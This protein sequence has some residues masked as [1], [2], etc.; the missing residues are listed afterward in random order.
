[1]YS[2]DGQKGR[3]EMAEFFSTRNRG[4]SVRGSEAIMKGI[5][6][7]GGL[8]VPDCFENIYGKCMKAKSYSDLCSTVLSSFFPE[9]D[10]SGDVESAYMKFSTNPPLCIKKAGDLH[11]M[12]L[13]HGPTCAFKDFALSVLPYLMRKS[14]EL[15]KD[16]LRTVI[17]TATSGDTG[18]AALEAFSDR[19]TGSRDIQIVVLYPQ[20]G[21]SD[22]QKRQMITQEGGNVSVIGINGNFDHA[23]S[24]VKEIFSDSGLK[25]E[26]IQKGIELSSANSINIG[27]LTPQ[28]AYYF[29]A[30]RE[31]LEIGDIS[32]GEEVSFCVPSGNFG[33]ILA[34]YYAKKM[35]LPVHRL[36][37]ASNEN[38]VLAEFFRTGTYDRRRELLCTSSPSMDILIS[39]NI[40]RL[41][42]HISESTQAVSGWMEKLEKDGFYSVYGDDSQMNEKIKRELAVFDFGSTD[43]KTA[44]DT[45]R[46][47]FENHGYLMDTHTAV[48][49][50]VAE[51]SAVSGVK[52]VL[53]TASPFKFASSVCDALGID[54]SGAGEF[55]VLDMLSA[56]T[57][58]EIPQPLREL[59]DKKIIHEL[60]ADRRDIKKAVVA[61]LYGQNK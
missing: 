31:L 37:C 23:Q 39:S 45:I 29:H 20:N 12:E 9:I 54:T 16:S 30:Y 18:K 10:I 44:Q 36:I 61:L 27:R 48:A 24:A 19:G 35:G 13:Y 5:A 41:L 51:K 49:F 60:T 46:R 14:R 43:H 4:E 25:D 57:G 42:Y 34:G 1:M 11:V 38:D 33:D 55:E 22:I 7:D 17:L 50:S 52:V 58:C 8:Y 2:M 59:K 21:V 32:E 40:E 15:E 6:G 3:L 28:V 56:E 47:T 26:L 53:S